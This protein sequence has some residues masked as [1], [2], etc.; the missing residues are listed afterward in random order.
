LTGYNY[1]VVQMLYMPLALALLTLLERL[2]VEW[3][4]VKKKRQ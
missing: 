3:P 2:A 4:A 1:A